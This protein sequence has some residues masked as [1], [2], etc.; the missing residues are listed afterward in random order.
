MGWGRKFTT[1]TEPMQDVSSWSFLCTGQKLT[2]WLAYN[3]EEIQIL[4]GKF[5]KAN[6]QLIAMLCHAWD[7]LCTMV[8]RC[9]GNFEMNLIC[10]KAGTDSFLPYSPQ[11]GAALDW[12]CLKWHIIVTGQH[13]NRLISLEVWFS[14]GRIRQ[15]LHRGIKE[16]E[17]YSFKSLNESKHPRRVLQ[18]LSL[19][20]ISERGGIKESTVGGYLTDAIMGGMPYTWPLKGIPQAQADSIMKAIDQLSATAG[21]SHHVYIENT[22][23]NWNLPS[24]NFPPW[25]CVLLSIISELHRIA[26]QN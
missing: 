14:L 21:E 13:G 24:M 9:M 17:S 15:S 26:I 19:A 4:S 25:T 6:E 2:F 16:N 5:T 23:S 7:S 12:W 10:M 20:Q 3:S 11:F 22:V 18:G 8:L 1:K